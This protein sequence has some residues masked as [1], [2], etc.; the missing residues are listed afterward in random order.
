[1]KKEKLYDV[2]N[3]MET[4]LAKEGEVNN[5]TKGVVMFKGTF[6][7]IVTNIISVLTIVAG[8]IS[9]VVQYSATANLDNWITYVV[10]LA[11]AIALYFTGKDSNGKSK[12]PI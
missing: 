4:L 6:K 5:K 12:K 7:D 3:E 8:V 1:M 11:V 2:L 10:G 9:V